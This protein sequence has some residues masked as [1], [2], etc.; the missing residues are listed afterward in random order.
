MKFI[1]ILNNLNSFC[2][3][4][5]K[6]CVL[7]TQNFCFYLKIIVQLSTVINCSRSFELK[8]FLLLLSL[9][10]PRNFMCDL[11][12]VFS[13]PNLLKFQF[14]NYILKNMIPLYSTLIA[15]FTNKCFKIFK[16]SFSS[17]LGL[18]QYEK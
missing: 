9:L 18:I 11:F 5:Q 4:V 12:G 14:H 17:L 8:T 15:C 6:C 13:N 16:S 10:T 2:I 1:I 7:W 3:F